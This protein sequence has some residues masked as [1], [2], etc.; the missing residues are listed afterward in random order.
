MGGKADIE[1]EVAAFVGNS[2]FFELT[3]DIV[4]EFQN[5]HPN[6][7]E[8]EIRKAFNKCLRKIQSDLKS[9]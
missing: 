9:V 1:K 7:S 2:A 5:E 6:L 4:Y 8:K 3:D